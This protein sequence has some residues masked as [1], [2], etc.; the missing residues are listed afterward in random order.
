MNFSLRT[1]F[2][3]SHKSWYVVFPF[4]LFF[5]MGFPR[6]RYWS[7]LQFPST[8]DLTDLGTKPENPALQVDS[9]PLSHQVTE[10]PG[11]LQS[12][13]SQE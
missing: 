8:G 6:Q 13:G 10:E 7:R 1:A 3:A 9:L 12:V 11:R 2:A 4:S 5:S